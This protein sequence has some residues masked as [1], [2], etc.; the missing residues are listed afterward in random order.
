MA[1]L[2]KIT[3]LLESQS[4]TLNKQNQQ[5]ERL[6]REVDV[7]NEKVAGSEEVVVKGAGVEELEEEAKRKDERI[8]KLELELEEARS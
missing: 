5:I 3:Q 2:S 1:Q 7:L 6:T 4:I 8:R